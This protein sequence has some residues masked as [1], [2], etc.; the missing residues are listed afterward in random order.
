MPCVFPSWAGL[1][2]L[3][4]KT[5]TFSPHSADVSQLLVDENT[6]KE[7]RLGAVESVYDAESGH[8]I[9]RKIIR[10]PDAYLDLIC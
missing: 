1:A 9:C 3:G 2:L 7:S 5:E 10:L 8:M 4:W 6:G